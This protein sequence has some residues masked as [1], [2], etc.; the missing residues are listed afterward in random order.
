MVGEVLGR[1]DKGIGRTSE[2]VI[3]QVSNDTV[4]DTNAKKDTLPKL[5]ETN[6]KKELKKQGVQYPHIVFAQAKLESNCGKSDVA[7]KYNNLFGLRKGTE[8]RKF[9]HWTES[10]TAYKKLVQSKY[11]GGSYL[12]FLDNIGYAEDPSYVKKL[13]EM[14]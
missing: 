9:N 11:S 4:S 12:A 1:F 2:P 7:R 6:L 5:S 14:I 13:K 10:V 3:I 8:Y